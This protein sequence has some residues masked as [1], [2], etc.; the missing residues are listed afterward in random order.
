MGK[1]LFNV[2]KRHRTVFYTCSGD[3]DKK[4][5]PGHPLKNLKTEVKVEAGSLALAKATFSPSFLSHF[6]QLLGVLGKFPECLGFT[7]CLGELMEPSTAA[8]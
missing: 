2:K 1:H 7:L 4:P 8:T 6:W 5:N 3:H